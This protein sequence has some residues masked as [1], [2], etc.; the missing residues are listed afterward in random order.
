M[1]T[2]PRPI[3]SPLN[4]HSFVPRVLARSNNN[5]QLQNRF[6][7]PQARLYPRQRLSLV[8]HAR[9][10]LVRSIQYPAPPEQ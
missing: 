1:A 8:L 5:T 9:P 4:T 6:H 10:R 3:N 7:N 2:P